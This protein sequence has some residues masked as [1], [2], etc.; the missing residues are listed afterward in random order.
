MIRNRVLMLAALLGAGAIVLSAC[1]PGTAAPVTQATDSSQAPTLAASVQLT[2]GTAEANNAPPNTGDFFQGPS[3]DPAAM[4]WVQ[5][6]AASAGDLNPVV[7]NGAGFT[8][9]RFD[10]DTARPSKSNCNGACA[11]TWPPVLVSPGSRI[12]VHGVASSQVGTVK[13]VDGT[14]QVTIGG[15]PVYKFS[16]DTKP[17]D[18]NGQGVG[19]TWFGVTP[20]GTKAGQSRQGTD[21]NTGLDYKNGTAKQNNAPQ[22]TG[23]FFNG[24]R[25][26]PAAMKWVQL[27]AGSANGLNPIVQDGAGF[28]LYRFDKDTAHPSQSNCNGAC[29]M[30]WPPVVVQPGSRIFV[31]GVPT[32]EIGIVMRADGT[33][34]VTI[35][36]SPAY[37]FSKDTA[38]G[39]TN[40]EGVGG[41]WFAVSPQGGKV[42]PPAGKTDSASSQGG[43]PT[44]TQSSSAPAATGSASG[45]NGSSVTLGNGSVILDSGTNFTEP[46][47]SE[48]VGGPGCKNVGQPNLASSLQ[49]SGG[50]MKIWTGPNCTGMSAVVSGDVAD[51]STIGFDKKITSIRFGG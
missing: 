40:G 18:T 16:K 42:L 41:T 43:S 25:T 33:R 21:S 12:F 7:V 35:G 11:V 13:R 44:R 9:Y 10:K 3:N 34:Q 38:P 37:R 29:A 14:V 22:N 15:W 31:H 17:G 26:D 51:L 23:D 45:S 19:G 36:G 24:P 28:T 27:T 39:Q 48:G 32:S 2:N 50:P 46:N 5:L 4:K 1:G 47:G 6:T 30:T 20:D 8:L 49:L